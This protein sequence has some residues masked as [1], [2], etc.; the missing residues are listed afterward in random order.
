MTN[1]DPRGATGIMKQTHRYRLATVVLLSLLLAWPQVSLA[2]MSNATLDIS[3]EQGDQHVE[4]SLVSA[5]SHGF[6]ERSEEDQ[7]DQSTSW[8][9]YAITYLGYGTFA[10]LTSYI[11]RWRAGQLVTG[12]LAGT[13]GILL[14]FFHVDHPECAAPV[15][16][17]AG[18]MLGG[19]SVY[20]FVIAPRHSS[21]TRFAVNFAG[22]HL[23]LV[24]GLVGGRAIERTFCEA[25]DEQ[26]SINKSSNNE[27]W[28]FYFSDS[29]AGIRIRF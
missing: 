27:Q 19:L 15:F 29:T 4:G 26:D 10:G 2:D 13:Y 25:N 7:N 12:G 23:A 20:N 16:L 8:A 28:E 3:D 9:L 18:L 5:G 1:N 14:S 24:S 6:E 11:T 22:W 21:R 17:P